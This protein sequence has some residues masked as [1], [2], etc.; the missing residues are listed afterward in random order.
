MHCDSE[1][2]VVITE[3]VTHVGILVKVDIMSIRGMVSS[4]VVVG[5]WEGVDDI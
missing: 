3:L 5:D 2:L 4:F 1:V